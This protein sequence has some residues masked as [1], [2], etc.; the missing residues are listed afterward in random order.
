MST[1]INGA[2]L[3]GVFLRVVVLDM[4]EVLKQMST[5][6]RSGRE[7]GR[8]NLSMGSKMFGTGHRC[9]WVLEAA[10]LKH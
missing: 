2:Y 5:L 6:I 3:Q 10:L 1:E 9:G 7:R 4:F 8:D